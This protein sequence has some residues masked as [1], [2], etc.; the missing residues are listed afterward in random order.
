M[1]DRALEQKKR[2]PPIA[3]PPL[4]RL[5]QRAV[6]GPN[7]FAIAERAKQDDTQV[8]RDDISMQM[9]PPTRCRATTPLTSPLESD[10]NDNDS[11]LSRS[12]STTSKYRASAMT[13]FSNLMDHARGSSPRK[14]DRD[15]TASRH[16]STTRSRH[17]EKS[18]FSSVSDRTHRS[19]TGEG[20]KTSRA[21]VEAQNGKK[22][23]QIMGHVPQTPPAGE[24]LD[25]PHCFMTNERRWRFSR[26]PCL[27]D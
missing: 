10:S 14:Q 23:F 25:Y 16:G 17:S 22:L 15:S 3:I 19:E 12:N 5:P 1:S 13:T 2:P 20:N 24:Y 6:P 21:E 26:V 7:A 4:P 18:H 27:D 8:M 9:G 11:R